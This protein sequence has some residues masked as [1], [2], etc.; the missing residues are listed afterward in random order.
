MEVEDLEMAFQYTLI[1]LSLRTDNVQ[2]IDRKLLV[3]KCVLHS[4]CLTKALISMIFTLS[5]DKRSYSHKLH[6]EK[7]ANRG[8][9]TQGPDHGAQ[10]R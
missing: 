2:Q 9:E 8:N 10:E 5:Q 6:C 4:K 3:C 7:R 1:S